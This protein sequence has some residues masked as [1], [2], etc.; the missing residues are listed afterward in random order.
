MNKNNVS[1]NT[2]YQMIENADEI[3]I[4]DF[5]ATILKNDEKLLQRFKLLIMNEISNEDIKQY[6]KQINTIFD[7]YAGR[8]KFIDYRHARGFVSELKEF[9]EDD[10]QGLLQTNH[11]QENFELTT[12]L[13]L[14]LGKQTIDDS[15][16]GIG[17][18][19]DR[20]QHIWEELLKRC[21]ETLKKEM[22]H[23]FLRHLDGSIIDYMEEYI[24]SIFFAHFKEKA[25]LDDKLK[26]IEKRLKPNSEKI[27]SWSY[28]YHRGKWTLHYI[29]I[30]KLQEVSQKEIWDYCKVHLDLH[31][32]RELYIEELVQ[33]NNIEEAI[34]ILKDGKEKETK[35]QGLMYK[36]SLRLKELYKQ[37]GNAKA[38]EEE[39]WSLLSNYRQENI[40]L[41]KELKSLF[42]KNK[43]EEKREIVFKN[44]RDCTN[45]C[46]FYVEEKLFDRLL[47]TVIEYKGLQYLSLYE[48]YL[49]KM[50]PAEL[51]SKYDLEIKDM[52][53][54]A[55]NR[56]AYQKLIPILRKMQKYPEGQARVKE[57]VETWQTLYQRRPA[58]MDE[59]R[60]L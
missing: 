60:K 29:E 31:E 14:K 38:Y 37:T 49:E 24:E 30:L 18:L 40:I 48:K 59:L 32:V 33:N 2:I 5:L 3:I 27:N 54:N 55:S 4:K 34:N 45:R 8:D 10:I 41:F 57:L 23:W 12:Y 25:F 42:S 22:F 19:S 17:F 39:L 1:E 13:F 44:T 46:D 21:G 26:L 9:L 16:G 51:L 35:Y 50:Y 43:W 6:K 28:E 56:E 36:Y 15:D 53:V 7:R 47:K 52:A 58:M 11:Y 20:C